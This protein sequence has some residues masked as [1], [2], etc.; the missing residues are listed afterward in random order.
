M[1]NMGPSPSLL[2]HHM[3]DPEYDQQN[4]LA[5]ALSN[6]NM[7]KVNPVISEFLQPDAGLCLVVEEAPWTRWHG[8]VDELATAETYEAA[9]GHCSEADKE[10]L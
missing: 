6:L 7:F 3:L 9:I 8:D 10:G 2:L 1:N 4:C 5:I